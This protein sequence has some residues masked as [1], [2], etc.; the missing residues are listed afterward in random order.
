[1]V[2]LRRFQ[3]LQTTLSDCSQ[4]K[5]VEKVTTA[6]LTNAFARWIAMYCRPINTFEDQGLKGIILIASGDPSYKPAWRGTIVTRI[7]ESYGS[8]NAKKAERLAQTCYTDWRPLEK[9]VSNHNYLGAHLMDDK[10]YLHC[11][12]TRSLRIVFSIKETK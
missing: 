6:K 3:A 5:S 4:S 11:W 1:M 8:E 7:C 10:C 9:S 12:L 2:A